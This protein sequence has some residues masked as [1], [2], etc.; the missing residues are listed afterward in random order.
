MEYADVFEIEVDVSET[1]EFVDGAVFDKHAA[2]IRIEAAII[3]T[4][5]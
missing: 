5:K 3:P 4:A 1:V 2:A